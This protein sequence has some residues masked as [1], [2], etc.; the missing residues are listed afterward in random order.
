M[1]ARRKAHASSSEAAAG[2]SS[3][4]G[5]PASG[6]GSAAVRRCGRT[7]RISRA[8]I[9]GTVAS[10]ALPSTIAPTLRSVET[11]HRTRRALAED[12]LDDAAQVAVVRDDDVL[13][14]EVVAPR[15]S[16]APSARVARIEEADEAAGEQRAARGS[17]AGSSSATVTASVDRRGRER[18]AD[19]AELHRD[20]R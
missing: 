19:G 5:A 1:Q 3:S 12:V 8:T 13:V 9:A 4:I 11:E 15:V 7:R 14:R 16:V 20:R 6:N 10:S 17:P 2:Q 18:V